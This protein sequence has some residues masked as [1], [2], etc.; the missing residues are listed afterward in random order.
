MVNNIEL[1][2]CICKNGENLSTILLREKKLE[3][4]LKNDKR[5]NTNMV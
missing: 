4:I 1:I 2:N 3:R 5:R